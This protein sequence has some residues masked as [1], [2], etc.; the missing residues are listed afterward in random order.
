LTATDQSS[1]TNPACR[2]DGR[3]PTTLT[4]RHLRFMAFGS[5]IGAGFFLASGIA[6]RNAGPALLA[7][8][9]LAGIFLYLIMRALGEM[10]LA[11]PAHGSF[12]TYA[13][14]FISPFV[15]YTVGWTFWLG[16]QLVG[17]AE[18][19][20][21]GLLVHQWMPAVPQWI[22]ALCT[23]SAVYAINLSGIRTFGELEYG[24]S[25]IKIVTIAGF[26]LCGIVSLVFK[27]G[28]LGQHGS[29][30]NLWTRGGFLP[31]G[32]HGILV[33]LPAVVFAFGGVEVI[34]LAAAETDNP[35]TNVPRAINGVFSRI[36]ILYIGSLGLV[37]MLIPWSSIDPQESPFVTVLASAGLPVAA[38]VVTFVAISALI[39]ASNTVLYGGSRM[40]QG[41]A[42]AGQA[43][44]SLTRLSRR[45]VPVNAVHVSVALL[46]V[47]IV[48]D[49][50][51]PG[52]VFGAVLSVIAWLVIWGW[53]NIVVAHMRCSR[54][55][56]PTAGGGRQ[57]RLPGRPFVD[58]F[59]LAA[60]AW[61][62][63]ALASSASLVTLYLLAIWAII[64]LVGYK[65]FV[66]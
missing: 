7:A 16:V 58:L 46:L 28:A 35:A 60:L 5:Q 42:L 27:I 31:T 13:T 54:T 21:V 47:G 64:L 1:S 38:G 14:K 25:M 36:L 9:L 6:I 20:G 30:S 26:I 18:I 10:T 23:V 65:V 45:G 57:Y 53:V 52:R 50:L 15:G 59:L 2:V 11:Y 43:P 22:P 63:F 44:K 34:G 4:S 3:S 33:A 49:D 48:F 17:V 24:L 37:M 12:S 39:S 40:L 19:T 66:K 41:L 62:M 51:A 29:V 56:V 32:M 61:F 55:P 8:Y